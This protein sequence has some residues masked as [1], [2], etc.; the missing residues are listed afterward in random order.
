[1]VIEM[2][3][4]RRFGVPKSDVER[5]MTHYGV[6]YGEAERGLAE[7]RYVLPTRGTRLQETDNAV[8]IIGLITLGAGALLSIWALLSRS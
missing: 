2:S 8:L 1:M 3:Y 6:S 7:G 4:E 5:V